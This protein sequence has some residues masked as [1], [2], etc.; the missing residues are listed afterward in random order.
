MGERCRLN[1]SPDWGSEPW[2]IQ[3]GEHTEI[4]FDCAFITHDGATWVFREE[5]RYNKVLRF[6]KIVIGDNCFI[7]ARSTILPGITIGDNSIIGAGSLV[8]KSIPSGEIWGGV[9]AKYIGKTAD[10]AEKCLKESLQYD[11]EKFRTN[12]RKEIQRML[13][14]DR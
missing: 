3:I 7:G 11:E 6:G 14:V 10:F 13:G 12:R 9:P 8:T 2:L 4:S 5:Q 1:G